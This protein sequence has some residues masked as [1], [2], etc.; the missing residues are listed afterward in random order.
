MPYSNAMSNSKQL[1]TNINEKCTGMESLAVSAVTA[2]TF[3]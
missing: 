1:H 2:W 3:Q